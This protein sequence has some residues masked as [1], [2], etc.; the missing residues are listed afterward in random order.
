MTELYLDFCGYLY[1]YGVNVEAEDVF[2]G[3]ILPKMGG[4][5]RP[6]LHSLIKVYYENI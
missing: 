3:R 2:I 5:L 4:G 1:Y 6:H